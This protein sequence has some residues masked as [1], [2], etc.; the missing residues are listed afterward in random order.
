MNESKK[1]KMMSEKSIILHTA[2]TN[3]PC[4]F[5]HNQISSGSLVATPVDQRNISSSSHNILSKVNFQ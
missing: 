3:D 1:K 4:I 2:R 5:N